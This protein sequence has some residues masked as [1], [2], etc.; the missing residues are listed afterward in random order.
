VIIIFLGRAKD[1]DR[2]NRLMFQQSFGPDVDTRP[3]ILRLSFLHYT[4]IFFTRTRHCEFPHVPV[5]LSQGS[6]PA[7][8]A[9]LILDLP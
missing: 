1:L 2:K 5:V 7:I 4:H 8:V 9:F 6:T 3:T